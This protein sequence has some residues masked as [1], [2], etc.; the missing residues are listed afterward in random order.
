MS[1]LRKY[2]PDTNHVLEVDNVQFRE[3]LL[4]EAKLVRVVDHQTNQLRHKEICL[5]KVFWHEEVDNEKLELEEE[6]KKV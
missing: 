5:I 4:V 2:R 1:H 3:D 6:V